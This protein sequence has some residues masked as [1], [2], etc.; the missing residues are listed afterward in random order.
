MRDRRADFR[1]CGCPR[2]FSASSF[3]R[4]RR[5]DLTFAAIDASI[6]RSPAAIRCSPANSSGRR[7]RSSTRNLR[8]LQQALQRLRARARRRAAAVRRRGARA[9]S[10]P[11]AVCRDRCGRRGSSMSSSES[12]AS[13]TINTR[14][15]CQRHD[16]ETISLLELA[17]TS[18]FTS[19]SS[20]PARRRSTRAGQRH[21][22]LRVGARG[23]QRASAFRAASS[24]AASRARRAP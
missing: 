7:A 14:S 8:G 1:K 18:E 17:R 6:Q 22:G 13:F 21:L 24:P 19:S 20:R 2:K 15:F 3:R 4:A 12:P 16:F 23:Q 11:P 9:A 5:R 10:A